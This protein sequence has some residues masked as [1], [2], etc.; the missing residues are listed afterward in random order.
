MYVHIVYLKVHAR[1]DFVTQNQP[2]SIQNLNYNK[3]SYF[4]HYTLPRCKW[5][6]ILPKYV[7]NV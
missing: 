5:A 3:P 2:I 7:G 4:N 1:W 6:N